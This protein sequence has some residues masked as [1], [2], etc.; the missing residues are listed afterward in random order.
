MKKLGNS[1]IER[2]CA[3]G[4][5]R[6]R[7]IDRVAVKEITLFKKLIPASVAVLFLSYLTRAIM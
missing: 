2:L 6:R 7:D 1:L 3:A 4:I 5:V